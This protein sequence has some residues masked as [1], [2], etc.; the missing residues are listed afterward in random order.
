MLCLG[1]RAPLSSTGADLIPV[2]SS[3][4]GEK[5]HMKGE[6]GV[7]G[8]TSAVRISEELDLDLDGF[9]EAIDQWPDSRRLFG[10]IMTRIE[11]GQASEPTSEVPI[12][13]AD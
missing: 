10:A 6:W 12:G 7:R 2:E 8:S 9:F 5:E 4:S 3:G 13:R 1:R 11:T